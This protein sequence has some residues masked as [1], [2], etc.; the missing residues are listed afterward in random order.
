MFEPKGYADEE[1]DNTPVKLEDLRK[2]KLTLEQI[3]RLRVMRDV[4]NFEQEKKKEV[5][6]KQYKPAPAE[7][8]GI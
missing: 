7:A 2:V 5:V 6:G 8:G 4:R 3:G 1:Q